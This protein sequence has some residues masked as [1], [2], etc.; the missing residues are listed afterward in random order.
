MFCDVQAARNDSIKSKEVVVV[1]QI[2]DKH[3]LNDR[4]LHGLITK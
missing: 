4:F 2:K 3:S 1:G